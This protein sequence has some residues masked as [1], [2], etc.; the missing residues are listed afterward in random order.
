M[1]GSRSVQDACQTPD[2]KR[3]ERRSL[4][5]GRPPLVAGGT[6]SESVE[7]PLQRGNPSEVRPFLSVNRRVEYRL[8]EDFL[9]TCR[10]CV[11]RIPQVVPKMDV[12]CFRVLLLGSRVWGSE[13][14]L[15]TVQT[16]EEPLLAAQ[17]LVVSAR[18]AVEIVHAH[19]VRTSGFCFS[20][21]LRGGSVELGSCLFWFDLP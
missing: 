3:D 16:G 6:R 1:L 5:V 2:P 15:L 17:P 8:R 21:F 7:L 14:G 10:A 12:V 11:A 4:P 19:C 13:G 20:L 9:G 18:P